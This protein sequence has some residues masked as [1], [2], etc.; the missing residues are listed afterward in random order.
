MPDFRNSTYLLKPWRLFALFLTACLIFGTVNS[1]YATENLRFRHILKEATEQLGYI[2]TI[3]Q[4]TKGYMWF[5]GNNGL[6]RYDGYT[7]KLY[8]ANSTIP[9]GLVSSRINQLIVTKNGDIWAATTDTLHLYEPKTD[10]FTSYKNLGTAAGS[11][12]SNY[13]TAILEQKT[14]QKLWVGTL[15]GLFQ[16]DA[17]TH[18]FS[19]IPLI[20][21]QS[22]DMSAPVVWTL[23]RDH[24]K[25]ILIGT[26]YLGLI[27]LS[28]HSKEQTSFQHNPD[29]TQSIANNDVRSVLVDKDNNIWIGMQGGYINRINANRDAIEFLDQLG[30]TQDAIKSLKQDK[31]GSIWAGHGNGLAKIDP[32][33]L[34]ITTYTNEHT[35]TGGL[36]NISVQDIYVSNENDIWVGFYP[37]GVDLMDKQASAFTHIQPSSTNKSSIMGGGIAAIIEDERGN[38]W[39]G[40]G[41]GL[42]HYDT[43]NRESV[44]HP[45]QAE[46][47]N[48]IPGHSVLSLLQDKYGDIWVGTWT[49]GLSRYNP[50]TKKYQHYYPEEGNPHSLI[51]TEIWDIME[52]RDGE[53]WFATELGICKYDRVKD[54]FIR[55]APRSN[56]LASSQFFYTRH[57]YEDKDRNIWVSSRTGLYKLPPARDK[58]KSYH[59][60][61]QTNSLPVNFV[62]VT[63]EDS[64]NQFWLGTHGGGLCLF[65]RLTETCQT[66]GITEGLPDLTITG[67]IEDKAG[68]LWITTQRGLSKFNPKTQTFI[69]YFTNNGLLEN[70][71]NRN[72]PIMDKQGNIIIG[73]TGG[74]TI[75]DPAE[76]QDNTLIPPIKITGLSI[77]NNELNSRDSNVLDRPIDQMSTL[78]LSHLQSVFSFKF[79]ALSYRAPEDNQ[80]SY[81]MLGF[82]SK[83]MSNGNKQSATFTNL[84]PG[85][86]TFQVKG[87]NNHVMWNQEGTSIEVV[88]TPPWWK[89]WWARSLSIF[90]II[91]FICWV[92]KVKE[93]QVELESERSVNVKL[94]KLDK[95][96]DAFLANTSHELR[97]PLNGII[98]LAEHLEETTIDKLSEDEAT[99]LKLISISGKRLASLINDIL[100]YSKMSHKTLD[101]KLVATNLHTTINT[102]FSLL[103]QTT[104]GKDLQLVN[105]IPLTAPLILADQN[106][107][108]QILINI[109][110][111][112]IKYTDQG[113]IEATH[114]IHDNNYLIHIRDTGIGI[115]TDD[116]NEIFNVFQQ[117][118]D[119]DGRQYSG[120]GLGLA[121]TKQ[122]VEV[123]G[124]TINVE[125]VLGKGST[126]SI[127]LSIAESETEELTINSGTQ[128]STAAVN[129]LDSSIQM[130]N[131]VSKKTKLPS[132][133][134]RKQSNATDENSDFTILIVDDDPVNR[135]VLSGVLKIDAY[136]IIEAR[137]GFEAIELLDTNPS[138]D[139][140]MLDVMMPRMSGFEVCQT[141]RKTREI[142]DLPIIFL[143]AKNTDD[144][145]EKG[146]EVGGNEFMIKPISKGELLPR[147][148]NHLRQL[149]IVREYKNKK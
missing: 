50:K 71:F 125:S 67:I 9:S 23:T 142:Q 140:I 49:K 124:G 95:M 42:S 11:E 27:S 40:S 47:V 2:N 39:V 126:F 128:E 137:D 99:K 72:T 143:T 81:R 56:Q 129:L 111:N 108:Q 65:N 70:V 34:N 135:I 106:R 20:Q 19:P 41:W 104:D 15:A 25:H 78:V 52:T 79:T 100:D 53:I 146:F 127:T 84:D 4:D 13:V 45:H 77:F 59:A 69:N 22:A 89:T 112:S 138:I 141:I 43:N 149:Q 116:I 30:F 16:F 118:E 46:N 93:K 33:T 110:G 1:A 61:E 130:A 44:Q 109:V 10:R 133:K 74:L 54:R 120:T 28:P 6:G 113:T 134:K 60:T 63:Y 7:L 29:N 5:G 101:I 75:F 35:D 96:K 31:N 51:G 98:G 82:S 91:A 86:Y 102:V 76:L 114:S 88:I 90:S 97:T 24:N 115:C 122:L 66:Y 21:G 36:G 12:A 83:W 136:K 119:K 18:A 148:K 58:F 103:D 62:R 131:N 92:V 121:I 26:D 117:I 38:L 14:G 73:S 57:I 32:D 147:V 48:S 64:N 55:F 145:L 105:S 37:T 8:Q 94:L 68:N 107:L 144:D 87:S 139:L 17:K 123:Q 80:Y 132:V 3:V 85:T